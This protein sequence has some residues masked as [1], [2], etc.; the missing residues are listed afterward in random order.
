MKCEI[1]ERKCINLLSLSSHVSHY[2][3]IQLKNYYDNYLKKENEGKCLNCEK[4][5][6]FSG[7]RGYSKYCSCKCSNRSEI[8]K[9][10]SEQ[11]NLIKRGV[12]N[13]SQSPKV[14]EKKIKTSQIHYGKNHPMQ[15][16]IIQNKSKETNRKKYGKDHFMKTEEGKETD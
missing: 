6:K 8:T 15:C 1:C 10:K 7:I 2:H 4:E 11:T 14:K 13:A 3:K 16:K 9:Q 5:T 12:K